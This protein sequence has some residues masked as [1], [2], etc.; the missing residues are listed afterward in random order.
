LNIIDSLKQSISQLNKALPADYPKLA[1]A[2]TTEVSFDTE[3][4]TPDQVPNTL[5]LWKLPAEVHDFML[6]LSFSEEAVFKT[7]NFVV[8]NGDAHLD[9]FVAS[10]KN[11]NNLV[12][13][14]YMKVT[15]KATGIQ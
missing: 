11:I 1:T 5:A 6:Q 9:E 2:T 15:A 8:Q 14:T 7:Y 13:M 3:I 10:G 4:C 12:T